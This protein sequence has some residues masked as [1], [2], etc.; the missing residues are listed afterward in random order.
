[1]ILARRNPFVAAYQSCLHRRV[2]FVRTRNF[3]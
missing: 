1:V 2:Q 3:L